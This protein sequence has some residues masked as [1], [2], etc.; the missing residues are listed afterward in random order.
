MATGQTCSKQLPGKTLSSE[1][2]SVVFSA[3]CLLSGQIPR[4]SAM[5]SSIGWKANFW[6]KSSGEL[7]FF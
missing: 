1:E 3:R 4:C 7:N 2:P 6:T 5:S